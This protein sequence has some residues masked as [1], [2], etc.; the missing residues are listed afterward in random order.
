MNKTT[1]I[2]IGVIILV[3]VA[4]FGLAGK[5]LDW[6]WFKSIGTTAVFWASLLTGPLMK[7]V[8]G[9]FVFGFF[10][11]NFVI[12]KKA[13][14]R[15][16]SVSSYW[17]R[18]SSQNITLIGLAC[19][20][21]LALVITLGFNM[22][23]TTIQQFL[24]RV[25]VGTTDPVF[26]RDLGYY[27]FSYPFLRQFNQLAEITVIFGLIVVSIIYFLAKAFWKQDNTWQIWPPAKIHLT[28][29]TLIL[30]VNKIWGYSLAKYGLLFQET[31]RLTGVNYTAAHAKIAAYNILTGLLLIIIA[32]L[33]ASFLR[34]SGKILFGSLIVWLAASITLTGIYPTAIQALR[35][36]PN[37]YEL[38][39]P[40]LEN[41]IQFTRQA[42]GIDRIKVAN[43]DIKDDLRSIPVI[44]NPALQDLRLWDYKPLIP[45]YNQLQA[46]R[47]YYQFDDVDIDRYQSLTGQRQVMI[48]ARELKIERLPE[49]ARTW[50][51]LH[52]TYTHGLGIA[53][54]RVNQYSDQGQPVFIAKDL[55]PQSVSQFPGLSLKQPEIY[56]GESSNHYIIVNTKTAEFTV[57]TGNTYQGARG[58]P[59][60]SAFN[61]LL[62]ALKYRELNFLLSN[63]LTA[64]S[65]LL[66]YRNIAER[67]R[68][69]APF[70][71]YDNDPYPVVSA[72]K[73]YWIIDAYSSSR[74]Y[75]YAKANRSGFNYLRNPVKVIIDAYSGAADFY[76]TDPADPVIQVWQKAFPGL[77]KPAS[78]AAPDLA[79]HF[80]YPELLL[81]VQ[82]DI[83]AQYHMT[84]PKTFYEKEDYWDIPSQGDDEPF[85]PYYV[86]LK[87]PGV[88]KAEFLLMQPFSPRNKQNLSSWL[89]ARCDQPKYGE[90]LLYTLPK[91]QNIYGPGQIDS[92]INQDQ[93]ISQLVTLWNQHQSKV[94]WG[95]LLMIPLEDTILY[96][97][98]LYLESQNAR[99]AELK[100]IVIVYQNQVLIGDTV[101]QALT[102]FSNKMSLESSGK[103]APEMDEKDKRRL[104][105]L[106]RFEENTKEQQR[107]LEE[108]S[109]LLD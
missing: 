97:K 76:V 95:K 29:L 54:N 74:Y 2:I 92:R 66:M 21:L 62:M 100:K 52:L 47:P 65:N 99:Q 83:L 49:Q 57:S 8:V 7:L 61:R 10:Y 43:F 60:D 106:K 14:E 39:K 20:V 11:L 42:Y 79:A 69:L 105:L 16:K 24:H 15:I 58:I 37:E 50:I 80:R 78:A 88:K 107:L 35:V 31:T 86:T 94:L 33:L 34:R 91:D 32:A 98:P 6:L 30:A 103:I 13:F 53:A 12:V 40:Y 109:K 72:G 67:V 38:E 1:Q 101:A 28:I 27:M 75:P 85:E 104:E 102:G 18:V 25:T 70:L 59:L 90:L 56:F 9:L 96:I 87:L 23:W 4:V 51:N 22:D 55:P 93:T 81:I 108:L 46:I 44:A 84:N 64:E 41:H 89:I 63:Q 45:S 17:S 82:R 68:K 71:Y 77:F 48:G 5:Y 36:N 73:I 3:I 26:H 19:C